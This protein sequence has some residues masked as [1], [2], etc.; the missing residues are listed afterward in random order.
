MTARPSSICASLALAL[1]FWGCDLTAIPQ[2]DG[3]LSV[4]P[5]QQE[6]RLSTEV[7][8]DLT[9]VNTSRR[10]LFLPACGSDLTFVVERREDGTWENYKGG[11]CRAIYAMGY[12]TV[13]KPGT[14]FRLTTRIK[15]AGRYRVRLTYKAGRK[16]E[17]PKIT[18]SGAFFIRS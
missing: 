12:R 4:Q 17:R 6:Y 13:A 3:A 9:V 8:V 18:R 1:V 16:A 10:T 5:D 14:S 15:E 2:M 7:H 11:F